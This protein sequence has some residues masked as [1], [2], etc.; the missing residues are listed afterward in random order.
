MGVALILV[1]AFA[2]SETMGWTILSWSRPRN[3][4]EAAAFGL[5]SEVRRLMRD[6][7]DP[8][9]VYPVAP[10]A[11]SS[12]VRRVTALEAAV[13]GRSERLIRLFDRMGVID[14]ETLH[15]LA[16]LAEDVRSGDIEGWL[17]T[18]GVP[19]CTPGAAYHLV[20]ERS[21]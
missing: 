7:Q 6:G 20:E 8:R 17:K 14:A 18:K 12:A 5:G 11:I 10:D 1:A 2:V 21:R 4:A 19:P 9:A 15:H 16:C 13:W 3:V